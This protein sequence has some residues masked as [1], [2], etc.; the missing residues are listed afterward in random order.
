MGLYGDNKPAGHRYGFD[1]VPRIRQDFEA[2]HGIQGNSTK[3]GVQGFETRTND[4]HG[5]EGGGGANDIHSYL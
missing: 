2:D 1:G 3:G 4:I 5:F